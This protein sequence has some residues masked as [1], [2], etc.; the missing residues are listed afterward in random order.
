MSSDTSLFAGWDMAAVGCHWS[1]ALPDGRVVHM[2]SWSCGDLSGY[3]V[4]LDGEQRVFPDLERATSAFAFLAVVAPGTSLALAP[5][6]V[7]EARL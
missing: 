7:D 2:S 1:R 4:T 6:A 3:L 5:G